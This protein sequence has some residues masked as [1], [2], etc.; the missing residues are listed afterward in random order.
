[1]LMRQTETEINDILEQKE[2]FLD[3]D[4]YFDILLFVDI[5]DDNM[6]NLNFELSKINSKI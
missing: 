5:I 4:F 1:M 2:I 6:E 3:F